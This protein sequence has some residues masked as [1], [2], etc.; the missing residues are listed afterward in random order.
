MLYLNAVIYESLRVHPGV[1]LERVC[2]KEFELPPALP[3]SK[4]VIAK[5]GMTIW[6]PTLSIH[7][8]PKYYENP[9]KI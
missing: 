6:I 5:P 2:T 1:S 7:Y 4:P 3:G 9:K 8:D